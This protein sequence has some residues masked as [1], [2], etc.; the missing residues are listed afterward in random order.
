MGIYTLAFVLFTLDLAKRSA[1]VPAAVAARQ[2][3]GQP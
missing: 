3:A 1:R 2:S